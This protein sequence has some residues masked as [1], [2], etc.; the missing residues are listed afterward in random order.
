L[1]SEPG[2]VPNSPRQDRPG[3]IGAIWRQWPWLA[4]VMV[5][6]VGL[7]VVALGNWRVGV[8][9]IAGAALL[10]GVLRWLLAEPGILAIRSRPVDVVIYLALGG[11]LMVINAVATA[12]W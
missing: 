12:I 7:L 8:G 9:L 1:V 11:A 6:L 2:L 5:A 4:V 10:A 3:L